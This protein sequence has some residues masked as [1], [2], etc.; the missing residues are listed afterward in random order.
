MRLASERCR[1]QT[2]RQSIGRHQIRDLAFGGS[3]PSRENGILF[4]DKNPATDSYQHFVFVFD[5][6]FTKMILD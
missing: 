1:Q 5:T 2:I 4:P 3:N 6:V